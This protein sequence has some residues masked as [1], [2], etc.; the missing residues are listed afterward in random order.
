M[1][2]EG[3]KGN[4]KPKDTDVVECHTHGAKRASGVKTTWGALNEIQRLA[5]EEGIDVLPDL[6]CLLTLK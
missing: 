1:K 3:R 6:P 5:V 4:Y 2:L